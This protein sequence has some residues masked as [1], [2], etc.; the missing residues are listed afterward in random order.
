MKQVIPNDVASVLIDKCSVNADNSLLIALS[1]GADSMALLHLLHQLDWKVEAAHCNFKLRG[2][3]SDGDEKL[4]ENYCAKLNIKLHTK[5]FST[6]KYAAEKKISIEMAARELRYK[7]F[8]ELLKEHN[9]DFV[10]SGHH[11]ND[12]IETFFLN[13]IRGSGVKGLTGMSHCNEKVLRPLLSYPQRSILTYCEEHQIPYRNDSSNS[14]TKYLRNKIRHELIPIIESINPSFFN[15]MQNNMLHLQ[16]AELLLE[17][18]ISEFKENVLVDEHGHLIIPISKLQLYAEKRTILFEVL[19]PYGFNTTVVDEVI[20]QLD[21]LSGKQFF[22][23]THR[24]IKDRHNLLVLEKKDIGVDHFWLE[25][26]KILD[27]VNITVRIYDK[28]KPFSFSK[29][30]KVIHL[31]ADALELPLLVRRWQYGDE[32]MPLGMN[33]FKKLSD[34]FIDNKFSLADKE[35]TWIMVSGEDIVWVMGHRI[36]DR[37]KTTTRTQRILEV[38]LG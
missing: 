11:G 29:S 2:E 19:R 12:N 22:S 28:P 24:L 17:Q 7:W 37:F 35:S 21:G 8:Y 3:E 34:F 9:L 38:R 4:V 10:L 6:E 27:P 33:G 15:T 23:E 1:G 13:L 26:G 14:D 31:D 16:E 5:S 25:E 36:D 20:C 18:V 30:N 32:F